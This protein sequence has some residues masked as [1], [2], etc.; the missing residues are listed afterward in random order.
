MANNH[1]DA[2]PLSG[3]EVPGRR[4]KYIDVEVYGNLFASTGTF[5]G[6][7]ITNAT[8]TNADIDQLSFSK[9]VAGTSPSTETLQLGG[10]F[11][12]GTSGARVEINANTDAGTI[13]MY[14]GSGSEFDN[15]RIRIDNTSGT[16]G[17]LLI[18]GPN[19][20]ASA[21]E[22]GYGYLNLVSRTD[23][24]PDRSQVTLTA[25]SDGAWEALTEIQAAADSGD[26]S[27]EITASSTSGAGTITMTADDIVLSADQ[28]QIPDGS[29]S[30]PA[31]TFSATGQQDVGIY[32]SGTDEISFATG[33]G[34]R[35]IIDSSGFLKGTSATGSVA[36]RNS[37]TGASSPDYSFRGDTNTGMYRAGADQIGFATNGAQRLLVDNSVVAVQAG[38]F[39]LP[40]KAST[41][42]P[43]ATD[44]GDMYVNSVDNVLKVYEGGSWRTVASW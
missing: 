23:T 36:M 44:E 19:F 8:I 12:T 15:G 39:R 38:L 7:T 21:S 43:T 27:V 4:G 40:V 9:I 33:G 25:V 14:T 13:A 20:G 18:D 3:V 10:S 41:G 22:E 28:V 26:A 17:Q 2:L 34:Q 42:D 16:Y 24:T 30:A 32:R 6:V 29:A 11:V 1:F 37:T 31:L 5:D 35:W